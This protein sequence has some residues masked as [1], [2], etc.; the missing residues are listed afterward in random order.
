MPDASAANRI[1]KMILAAWTLMVPPTKALAQAVP[2]IAGAWDGTYACAQ[3]QTALH[4]V[5]NAAASGAI[6]AV[7]SFSAPPPRIT[8]ASGS[9]QMQGSFDSDSGR[10]V[11]RPGNWLVRPPGFIT[12][13]LDGSLACP[14][15]R[16]RGRVI[17]GVM[18]STFELYRD[19]TTPCR[20][21]DAIS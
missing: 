16:L 10:V 13:G 6:T 3:G 11:L 12:V 19:D 17:G 15:N 18:C 9:F 2:S 20:L 8:M 7:F 1:M 14:S 4:L 21:P 5:I